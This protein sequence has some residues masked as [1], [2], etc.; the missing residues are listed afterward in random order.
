[1]PCTRNEKVASFV[2]G[3][4][5]HYIFGVKENQPRLWNAAIKADQGMG[6]FKV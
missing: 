6:G 4:A 3:N 2:V 1:M 5:G